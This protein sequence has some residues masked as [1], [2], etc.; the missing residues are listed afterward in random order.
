MTKKKKTLWATLDE[1]LVHKGTGKSVGQK[2]WSNNTWVIMNYVNGSIA[3]RLHGTDIIRVDTSGNITLRTGGY[4]TV[5]TKARINEFLDLAD[6]DWKVFQK[7]HC[8]HIAH[9]AGGGV[10]MIHPFE[11]GMML[12]AVTEQSDGQ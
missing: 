6:T 2:K 5:T 11:E 12:Y 9:H 3:V 4:R 7:D 10:D 1:F 8:W